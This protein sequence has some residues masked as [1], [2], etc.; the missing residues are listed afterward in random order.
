MTTPFP[1]G[2]Y[3]VV[4]TVVR[5]RREPRILPDNITGRL[6]IGTRR[7][8]LSVTTDKNNYTWGRVSEPDAAGIAEWVCIK[9]L[10][11]TFMKCIEPDPEPD[12]LRTQ[13][14]KLIAWARTLGYVD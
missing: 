12:D 9:D 11:R 14:L 13:V 7:R 5:V 2:E 4:S 3:E 6:T 8:V 10:N 1:T